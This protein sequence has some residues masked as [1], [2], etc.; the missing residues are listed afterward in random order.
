[1][2]ESVEKHSYRRKA[3]AFVRRPGVLPALIVLVG[4]LIHGLM[5]WQPWATPQAHKVVTW[6]DPSGKNDDTVTCVS[7]KGEASCNWRG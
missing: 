3:M 5:V 4:L 7:F 2:T 6:K 1:M